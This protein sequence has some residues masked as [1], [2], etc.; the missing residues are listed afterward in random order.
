MERSTAREI[1]FVLAFELSFT[2]MSAEELLDNRLTS[3]YSSGLRD[4]SG[5]FAELPN[6]KQDDYIRRVVLGVAEHGAEL[7]ADIAK[8]SSGW[9]FERIPLVASA[10]MRVAMFEMLYMPDI[11]NG[12]AINEAVELAKKYEEPEIAAF[13]NGIL[14]AFAREECK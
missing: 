10:I 11:P 12:A 9:K 5:I 13:V 6:K 4:E 7:D 14:G 2:D 1:A 8:Y 3:E